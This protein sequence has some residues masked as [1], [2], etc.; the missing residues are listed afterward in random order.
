MDAV[1]RFAQDPMAHLPLEPG[2]ERVED[3]RFILTFSPGAHFWSVSVG[4]LRFGDA[5]IAPV[6]AEIRELI[7]SRGRVAS[8]WS[9]GG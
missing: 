8:V 1:E 2:E 3:A 4:R 7:R 5:A 9:V 6:V